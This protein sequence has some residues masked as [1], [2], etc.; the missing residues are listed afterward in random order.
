[1]AWAKTRTWI[2][3]EEWTQIL[4]K[5]QKVEKLSLEREALGVLG[6]PKGYGLPSDFPYSIFQNP[7]AA[8][9]GAMNGTEVGSLLEQCGGY[10]G[11]EKTEGISIWDSLTQ[12]MTS[13]FN[14][15][16][17]RLESPPKNSIEEAAFDSLNLSFFVGNWDR[18]EGFRILLESPTDASTVF[19]D[20]NIVQSCC[21]SPSL[22]FL[23]VATT[24][25]IRE[26]VWKS[27]PSSSSLLSARPS[28]SQITDEYQ[29][30]MNVSSIS[31]IDDGASL[32]VPMTDSKARAQ[33]KQK[34]PRS[35]SKSGFAPYP[36]LEENPR[37]ASTANVKFLFPYQDKQIS[38]WHLEQHPHLPY[39]LSGGE[40]GR[41]ILWEYGQTRPVVRYGA[42]R[43][44]QTRINRVHFNRTGTKMGACDLDGYVSL[45]NFS[46]GAPLAPVV[47]GEK[48]VAPYLS[49]Q[50]HSKSTYDFCFLNEGSVIATAGCNSGKGYFPNQQRPMNLRP[51]PL[52]GVGVWDFLLPPHRS[53]VGS[54]SYPQ[55]E[56]GATSIFYSPAHH[57]LV[58][59]GKKGEVCSFDLR[60]FQLLHRIEAHENTVKSLCLHPTE[61]L[62]VSGSSDGHIKV[63]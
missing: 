44:C 60:T 18:H 4:S 34:S 62:F 29:S 27:P 14:Q 45:W 26:F 25:S 32:L 54:L 12:M 15:A 51:T 50:C 31:L 59:G 28:T 52:G 17:S 11:T 38:V 30:S 56:Q 37:V 57:L 3:S 36:F 55:D 22:P 49:V 47:S 43:E 53:L 16:R 58:I 35:V 10:K 33:R 20:K 39:Y 1:M 2:L 48:H 23:A 41:V 24:D 5:W 61:R 40:K 46:S 13:R 42:H 7:T 6:N 19:Q 21:S 9:R 63:C 8:F